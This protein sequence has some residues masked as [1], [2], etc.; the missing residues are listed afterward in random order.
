MR[1]EH[2]GPLVMAAL[3]PLAA[4]QSSVSLYDFDGDGSLDQDDCHP[5]DPEI[6]P[7]AI[8]V[9]GDDIDQNCD[10]VDGNSV[11]RD[12]DGYSNAIDCDDTDPSIHPGSDDPPGDGID[13]NCDGIDGIAVDRDGDHYSDAVDCDDEDPD[14][15][16]GADDPLGDG[17]DQNCDG[18]DGVRGAGDD[19]DSSGDDDDSSGDDDGG[20]FELCFDGLDNDL[21]GQFDCADPDCA[22]AGICQEHCFDG[23]DNDLDG[24]IDCQDSDCM[25]AGICLERCSDGLDNDLDG[26]LDCDDSDCDLVPSCR[27][28]HDGDNDGIDDSIEWGPD[29]NNPID[30]DG[31]GVPDIFDEDS[32]NDGIDDSVEGAGDSDG[33]GIP[34]YLDLDSDDDGWDDLTEGS[35]DV[36]G[37]GTPNYLDDDSDDDGILDLF[38]NCPLSWDTVAP[39][40]DPTSIPPDQT[41]LTAVSAVCN[42]PGAPTGGAVVNWT[43]ATATDD[44]DQPTVTYTITSASGAAA[45]GAVMAEAAWAAEGEALNDRFGFSVHL[46]GDVNGDG[47]DD[48]MVGAPKHDNGETNEG[49]AYLYLGSAL[50]LSSTP[51]WTVESDQV[52]GWLGVSVA[53]AGD[54]N[55]DGFD[56]VLIGSSPSGLGE[57]EPIFITGQG[58]VS[59]YLGSAAGLSATAAMTATGIQPDENFGM[60]VASAGDVNGDG[61]D[62]IVIGA[63]NFSNGEAGEGRAYLYLGSAAGLQA[64]PVWEVEGDQVGAGFGVSV[65]SAGDVNADGYDDVVIGAYRYDSGETDEGRAYLYLGS[66]AGLSLS[67]DW[68]AESDSIGAEFGR[69]VA[70]AGDVNGDGFDDVVVGAWHFGFDPSAAGSSQPSS[71]RAYVYHGSASGLSVTPSWEGQFGMPA[72]SP[73]G[74][75]R[76]GCGVA[77]AGDVNGDGFDDLFIGDPGQTVFVIESGA[78]YLYLGS[79]SGLSSDAT[80]AFDAADNLRFGFSGAGN[81]DVNGDG[82][83]DL[84]VG[85]PGNEYSYIHG[86]AFLFL[87]TPSGVQATATWSSESDQAGSSYGFSVSSAGD[88]NADGYDDVIVGAHNYENT[89]QNEGAAFL[90][91]GSAA[92][93]ESTFAW[94][95]E[96][97]RASALFGASVAAAGD[98]NGDGFA[99]VIVGAPRFNHY[100]L[101]GGRALLYLGSASGLDSSP[102]WTVDGTIVND[103]F[104]AWVA[105]AGDVNGDGYDDL[106]V[107]AEEEGVGLSG[108]AFL[109]LGSPTGPSTSADWSVTGSQEN[110]G[111]S[112]ASAGD[113]NG[114]G[115]DDVVIGAWHYSDGEA[116]EGRAYLYLGSAT[117]LSLSPDWTAEGNEENAQ[118]GNSVASAGD[119][120]GDGF[121][122]VVVGAWRHINPASGTARSAGAA[123]L[124]LGSPSGLSLSPQWTAEGYDFPVP[125]PNHPGRH[126]GWSVASAGDVNADGY[127]D[128]IVGAYQSWTS[129]A[130]DGTAHLYL[131]SAAGLS[132]RSF[133]VGF[134]DGGFGWSVASAG[135]VDGDGYSDVIVG[136]QNYSNGESNEGAAFIYRGYGPPVAGATTVASGD[137][138]ALGPHTIDITAT[139][140]SG[141]S[142]TT[143]FDV[144][145]VD[146][147]PPTVA[148]VSQVITACTS[149]VGADL[150]TW[151]TPSIG[152]ECSLLPT[153]LSYSVPSDTYGGAAGGAPIAV[154]PATVFPIAATTVTATATDAAG[155]TEQCNFIA[156]VQ[157]SEPP[158]FTSALP[159]DQTGNDHVSAVCGLSEAPAGGAAVNWPEP[160]AADNCDDSLSLTTTA[161][162]LGNTVAVAP[163]DVFPI[164]L[165][166]VILEAT[167][168]QGS[169]STQIFEVE[170][171]DDTQPIVTCSSPGIGECTGPS[172]TTMNFAP[173]WV[174]GECDPSPPLF[175]YTHLAGVTLF[176]VGETVVTA[177]VEDLAGNLGSCTYTVEITDTIEP[178]ILEATMPPDQWNPAIPAV[179]GLPAPAIFGGATV[180]WT[181]PS[182]LE[183]CGQSLSYSYID[184]ATGASVATTSG[185]IFAM[186]AHTITATATDSGGSTDT[187]SFWIWI[188]DVTA[189][190]VTAT[191][192]I[193]D[194]TSPAG[195]VPGNQWV[196]ATYDPSLE[197]AELP[198]TTS[199]TLVDGSVVTSGTLF[200]IDTTQVTATAVDS[201]I[202]ANTGSDDFTVQVLDR[203]APEIDPSTIPPNQ[204]GID[205]V[206][207]VCGLP[208]APYGGASVSWTAPS[209]QDACDTFV[210]LTYTAAGAAGNVVVISGGVFEI[211]S[212]QIVIDATDDHGNTES[213]SFE[214]EV[215]DYRAPTISCYGCSIIS[216]PCTSSAGAVVSNWV[217]PTITSVECDAVAPDLTYTA[218]LGLGGATIVVTPAT[219]F[220]IGVT[221]V[222]SVATDVAGNTSAACTYAIEVVDYAGACN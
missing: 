15:Y 90:Y 94:S 181:D 97:D 53:G 137:V 29:P 209:A 109:Y 22:L 69:S 187:S 20:D 171:V 164:G 155:N 141:N 17:I 163:G 177:T 19:D 151:P 84:I 79:S 215:Q 48:A 8:D 115:Y 219:V 32:D 211:G 216:E 100:S 4:C 62:D 140:D 121:D 179:C 167:D 150:V 110:L 2:L 67:P 116:D 93:T 68:T 13:Q 191:S 26:D 104:G 168:D 55:G 57:Y 158:W 47:Y 14:R 106:L 23:Y 65:A 40:I 3:L 16:P 6:H 157:D 128:V 130:N 89:E 132:D 58:S 72:Q 49:K 124:Y 91:L 50:G 92:G 144:A 75:A 73:I 103:L 129:F 122:D 202:R 203:I 87:G 136:A 99:D 108:S 200:P 25:A 60:S 176:P 199:Y 46:V 125:W 205:A 198:P 175:T 56:D 146:D 139:D 143:S 178:E 61:F 71:G 114:D 196:S 201:S 95:A 45:G 78:M 113:V 220:P 39:E 148:C 101:S 189:P 63:Y 81:G 18:V 33:D 210:N 12:V 149:S 11:D 1:R 207:A 74:E 214:V 169:Q 160:S 142:T 208:A 54:I 30:S 170:V 86:K 194:C 96:S 123:H 206:S 192:I 138:F 82:Y 153:V 197:C 9:Y 24:S 66:S 213:A 35:G 7:G 83:D 112:V 222:T 190:D 119:V 27:W 43:A 126:F 159:P 36:D 218:P 186:G 59:L 133:W 172:G 180:S 165:H 5:S 105:G 204:V 31:D 188:E 88:V 85:G 76:Y 70:S 42:L 161:I 98:V 37:D 80:M 135:D 154:T 107:G 145:V 183:V 34:D 131:G 185:D 184:S 38:D 221:T 44:C 118:F 21:D 174:G 166:S 195:A 41:G 212:H 156:D 152:G 52:E 193:L 77:S 102:A 134:Q 28:A 111:H 10:G 217:A 162:V 173:P 120:N 51:A 147:T 117:G 64:G 182:V 127:A